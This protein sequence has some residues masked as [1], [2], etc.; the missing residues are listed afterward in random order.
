[1]VVEVFVVSVKTRHSS[2]RL[3]TRRPQFL[4]LHKQQNNINIAATPNHF[5]I[6]HAFVL[7]ELLLELLLELSLESLLVLCSLE[8]L[9][10]LRFFL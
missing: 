1:L 8:L 7:F 5:D 3:S 6:L 10:T 9:C 2:K 4:E